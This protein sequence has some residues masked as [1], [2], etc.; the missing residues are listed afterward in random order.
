[1]RGVWREAGK[2][3]DEQ[4]VEEMVDIVGI[5]SELPRQGFEGEGRPVELVKGCDELG[6]AV[7]DRGGVPRHVEFEVNFD[8]SLETVSLDR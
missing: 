4:R 6:M 7:G 8:T 2:E 1:M 3:I 5:K